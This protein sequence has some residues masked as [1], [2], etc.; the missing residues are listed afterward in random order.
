ME[1]TGE[2]P[3]A[4]TLALDGFNVSLACSDVDAGGRGEEPRP[5][6]L[7]PAAL[8]PAHPARGVP[9]GAQPND[10]VAI[11][12]WPAPRSWLR[13]PWR[14]WLVAPLPRRRDLSTRCT[15]ARNPVRARN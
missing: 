2:K 15:G 14:T 8:I 5:R 3:D 13:S 6:R 11:S 10:S 12:A 9:L 4:T 7:D 1:R